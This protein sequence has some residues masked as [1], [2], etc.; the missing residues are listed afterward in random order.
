MKTY[1]KMINLRK[2]KPTVPVTIEC[3]NR[4]VR[5]KVTVETNN[6][7]NSQRFFFQACSLHIF[8]CNRQKSSLQISRAFSKRKKINHQSLFFFKSFWCHLLPSTLHA[9]S[10]FYPTSTER[11]LNTQSCRRLRLLFKIATCFEKTYTKTRIDKSNY[12]NL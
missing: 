5:I 6:P 10:N 8:P 7:L 12:I 3:S 2:E 11:N 1:K 4:V 9:E